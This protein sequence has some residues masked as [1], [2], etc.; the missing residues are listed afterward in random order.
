MYLLDTVTVSA[1]RRPEKAPAALRRWVA[2]VD[3]L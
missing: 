1:L 3:P 2:P